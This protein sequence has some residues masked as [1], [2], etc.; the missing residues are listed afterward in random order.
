[1]G[2]LDVSTRR[3]RCRDKLRHVGRHGVHVCAEIRGGD[4]RQRR[5]AAGAGANGQRF[6]ALT[7][8]Q[9]AN[10][11]TSLE[12]TPPETS[13]DAARS[14]L[15]PGFSTTAATESVAISGDNTSIDRAM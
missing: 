9:D 1:D 14:L 6:Q 13:L 4:D 11:A 3:D 2:L 7:A 8:Q 5:G 10:A 15:P 12:V